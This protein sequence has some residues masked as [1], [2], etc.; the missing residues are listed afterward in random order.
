[1]DTCEIFSCLIRIMPEVAIMMPNETGS[2]QSAAIAIRQSKIKIPTAIRSVEI[3]EPTNS[4]TQWD[5]PLSND[6]Q[7]AIST[8]VKS[9]R[10]L[11]PKNDIGILRSFSA[12]DSLRTPLST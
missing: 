7:S 11:F 4:G 5:N 9:D 8:V 2:T 10:S 1:M 6:A 3:T 12:R